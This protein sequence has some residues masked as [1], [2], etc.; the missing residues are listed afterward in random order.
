MNFIAKIII[1]FSCLISCS[2]NSNKNT[3]QHKGNSCDCTDLI[4]DELYNHFFLKERTS[5]FTGTCYEFFKTGEIS[6]SKQFKDGKMD[7][8]MIQF[9]TNGSIK[10]TMNFQQNK[11]NGTAIIYDSFGKDSL[12][13]HFKNGK[14]INN[15]PN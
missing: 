14:Q 8:K 2:N 7:G 11:I 4:L 6:I 3:I 5:P 9:Y 1:I 13:Q 15:N 10:S 12:I